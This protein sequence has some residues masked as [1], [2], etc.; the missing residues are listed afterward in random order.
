LITSKDRKS[1]FTKSERIRRRAEYKKIYR[2]GRRY[3]SKHFTLIVSLREEGCSRLGIAANKRI[4]NAVR[5][6]RIKRVIRELFR[7]NKLFLR[8]L[9]DYVFVAKKGADELTYREVLD[10]I[11]PYLISINNKY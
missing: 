10:E 7:K 4:G 11:K 6:N 8:P 2:S 1:S 3:H 9:R 5:R